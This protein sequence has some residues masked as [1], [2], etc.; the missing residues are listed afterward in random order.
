MG[1]AGR[2][3]FAPA[4]PAGHEMRLDEPGGDTQ[5]GIHKALVERDHSTSSRLAER[6]MR[7]VGA[8]DMVFDVEVLH[9]PGIADQ[10]GQFG[11]LIGSVQPGGDEDG[12]AAFL[13]A[14][15]QQRAHERLQKHTVWHRPGDI[16]N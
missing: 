15:G 16:A 2:E 9:H 10:L 5:I 4:R 6:H 12:D 11:A 8:G 3:H 7:R 14:G 1:D 13:Q